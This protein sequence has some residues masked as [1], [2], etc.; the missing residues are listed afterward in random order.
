MCSRERTDRG[1]LRGGRTRSGSHWSGLVMAPECPTR[2]EPPN[3]TWGEQRT[4]SLAA[5][6]GGV[7]AGEGQGGGGNMAPGGT[8]PS[9]G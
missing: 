2:F 5:K 4:A 9:L 6:G 3:P 7:H 8:C 1:A